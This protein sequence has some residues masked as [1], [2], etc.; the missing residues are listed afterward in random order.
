MRKQSEIKTHGRNRFSG[1]LKSKNALWYEYRN[2][3]RQALSNFEAALGV[4]N[5]SACLLYYYSMLNFAKAELLDVFTVSQISGRIGHGI[6]FNPTN[7]KSIS[8]DYLTVKAGVFPRLYERRTGIPISINQRIPIKA[9]L[10]N[11]PEIGTQ[12]NDT[13]IGDPT[14]GSFIQLLAS[15]ANSSWPVLAVTGEL[16][17]GVRS[18]ASKIF[19]REFRQVGAPEK[20]RDLFGISRRL[21]WAMEFYEA[22]NLVPHVNGQ[23]NLAGAASITWKLRNYFT[24]AQHSWLDAHFCPSLYRA[25]DVPMPAE[26][27]RYALVYYA[28]SLV[29]YKPSAFDPQLHPEQAYLFDA[30]ARECALPMLID[31][32][33]YLEGKAQLFYPEDSWRL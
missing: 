29:R 1:S 4:P 22:K 28:S 27:A 18:N 33:S 2:F 15:D 9:L 20:W 30:L 8:G 7:A 31:T 12:V 24:L 16:P 14:D 26:L 13:G 17:F 3:L 5:R 32:L 11:I 19:R 21:P 25:R 6:S 10:G 23:S